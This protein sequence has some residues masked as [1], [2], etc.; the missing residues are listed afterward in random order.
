MQRG[1]LPATVLAVDLVLDAYSCEQRNGVRVF[2]MLLLSGASPTLFLDHSQVWLL[3]FFKQ[4]PVY[5]HA[6]T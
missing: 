2:Q 6:F 1:E 3:C 5:L 4:A